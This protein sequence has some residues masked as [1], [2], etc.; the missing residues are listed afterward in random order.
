MKLNHLITSTVRFEVLLRE[1]CPGKKANGKPSLLYPPHVESHVHPNLPSSSPHTLP[2]SCS[3]SLDP[4]CNGIIDID[5]PNG[6]SE[7]GDRTPHTCSTSAHRHTRHHG[8][9]RVIVGSKKQGGGSKPDSESY[10]CRNVRFAVIIYTPH[11]RQP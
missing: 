1:T 8:D 11:F 5:L 4:R 7:R 3:S 6:V 2:L 9:S 10:G